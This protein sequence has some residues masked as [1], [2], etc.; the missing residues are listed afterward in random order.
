MRIQRHLFAGRFGERLLLA[1]SRAPDKPDLP[2]GAGLWDERNALDVLRKE[3]PEFDRRIT[4][5]TVVDFGCGKG[6]QSVAMAR[7]QAKRVL[8]VD[9]NE[10][11][12]EHGRLIASRLGVPADRIEFVNAL[13]DSSKERFD[14]VISQNSFEHFHDPAMVLRQMAS[15][16]RPGGEVLITFGPPWLSP[17]GSHMFFFTLVPWVNLLFSE[18]TVMRVRGRFRNDGARR[19]EDVE[20]GLNK[21]TVARFERLVRESGLR[22]DWKR[23]T[24]LKGADAVR[25]VPRLREF[26]I[27]RVSCVLRKEA[28]PGATSPA[29]T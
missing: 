16:L 10:S 26:F 4:G 3:F 15:A 27:T 13:S 12:L 24:C 5:K 29:R 20:G 18:G 6:W 7:N 2:Q 17:Y 19:Y 8:G 1:L 11:H 21:M 25:T 23:Y 22:L 9:M 14:V 28:R